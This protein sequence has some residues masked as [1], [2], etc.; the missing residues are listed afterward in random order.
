MSAGE[1]SPREGGSAANGPGKRKPR[2]RTR[3]PEYQSLVR[4]HESIQNE[5]ISDPGQRPSHKG[6]D[7]FGCGQHIRSREAQQAVT[8]ID[9]TI[10]TTVV[11]SQVFAVVGTV[12]LERQ[13]VKRVVEVRPR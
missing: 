13:A 7:R 5:S 1:W 3:L 9:Q 4:R 2:D 8:R 6:H 11:T 12:V 10:L